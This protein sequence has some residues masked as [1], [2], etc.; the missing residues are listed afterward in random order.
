MLIRRLAHCA[1]ITGSLAPNCSLHLRAPLRSLV[2]SLALSLSPELVEQCNISVQFSKCMESLC[3]ELEFVDAMKIHE[4]GY[5]RKTRKICEIDLEC[6][7]EILFLR[8]DM[9]KQTCSSV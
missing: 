8:R 3:T 7:E 2:C 5:A 4:L 6:S 1:A 9:Q